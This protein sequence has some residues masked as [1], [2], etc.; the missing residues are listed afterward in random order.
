MTPGVARNGTCFIELTAGRRGLFI[1]IGQG[2]G[3]RCLHDGRRSVSLER[4]MIDEH[5]P[6]RVLRYCPKCGAAALRPAGSKLWH[7]ASCGFELYLNVA[8]AVAALIADEQGRLLIVVRGEEPRKGMW[9]LPGGFA[10]P[11]E[12]AEAAL[13]REVAEELGIEVTSM[14]FLCSYPNTYEYMGVHYATMD[15]GF[16]CAVKD[17]NAVQTSKSEVQELLFVR[18]QEIDTAQFAFVSVGKVVQRYRTE[19][20]AR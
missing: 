10:D 5:E 17:I 6:S 18:P 16:V 2:F 7:C 20:V 11:G 9:D 12:S 8:A 19:V 4:D 13:R 15:L 1:E 14:R 3:L